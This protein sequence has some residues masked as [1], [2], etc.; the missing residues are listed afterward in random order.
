MVEKIK[1]DRERIKR[2]R[3]ER[4]ELSQEKF[5]RLLQVSVTTVSRWER[6][7]AKPDAHLE[8]RLRR[9]EHVAEQ[10]E[11]AMPGWR[12]AKWLERPNRDLK[13]MPPI[14]LIGS[15]Y[16]ALALDEFIESMKQGV[17]M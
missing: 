8:A 10:V 17:L 16:G 11:Q 3:A 13:G 5:A 4:L 7:K 14:D 2:L 12:L 1:I 15:D 6:G 9:I